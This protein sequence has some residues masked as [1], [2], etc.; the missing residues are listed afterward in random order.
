MSRVITIQIA[1]AEF[2]AMCLESPRL[3]GVQAEDVK[4]FAVMADEADNLTVLL[5]VKNRR[6][7]VKDPTPSRG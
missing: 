7:N 5:A 4:G 2:L 1:R 3:A 6:S